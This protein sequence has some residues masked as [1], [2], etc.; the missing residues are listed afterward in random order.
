MI[1]GTFAYSLPAVLILFWTILETPGSAAA[2]DDARRIA[3]F[4]RFLGTVA[5]DGCDVQRLLD[6]C[7]K[8]HE[9]ASYALSTSQ[10]QEDAQSNRAAL[11]RSIT[12]SQLES[13]RAKLSSVGDWLQLAEGLLS[14]LPLLRMEAEEVLSGIS[15]LGTPQGLYGFCVPE[16][17]K[18]QNYHIFGRG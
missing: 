11:G 5:A 18:A 10:A 2:H 12:L 13:I 1:R 4:I 9:V 7:I 14:Y 17:A 3:V 8:I 6:S 16:L 15:R